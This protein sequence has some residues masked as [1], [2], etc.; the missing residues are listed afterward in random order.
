MGGW[1]AG[2]GGYRPGAHPPGTGSASR[3]RNQSRHE[4][5]RPHASRFGG[6]LRVVGVAA[7][8]AGVSPVSPV[9]T[10]PVPRSAIHY[11]LDQEIESTSTGGNGGDATGGGVTGGAGGDGAPG[12]N[13]GTAAG[14][15]ALVD[16][17]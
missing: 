6:L 7:L 17:G 1:A 14:G 2:R 12:G 9:S 4:T 8:L 15:D 16:G 10:A 13:G 3:M 11:H 5:P